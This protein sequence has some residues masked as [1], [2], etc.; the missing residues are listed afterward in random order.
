LSTRREL[1][2]AVALCLLGSVLV[3]LAVSRTW[4]S[5]RTAAAAPLPSKSF[6]VIGT[7]LAPGARALALVGLAGTAAILA[8]RGLGR[9]V[10]GV[11]V[12]A[13]GAG[14]MAVVVRALADPDAAMRRAGPFVDV[15]VAPGA[16]LGPWPYVALFGALL[17]GIAGLVVVVRGRS[18]AAMSSR[19]D[20]PADRKVGEGSLW[21][22]LD[23]GEDP[24]NV[25]SEGGG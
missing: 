1:L 21:E 7:H 17:I 8:T 23:R 15:H 10:V 18:W 16:D 19:Y 9:A 14:V 5:Y 20:A 2:T 13:A 4:V 6:E 22:A 11:L 25:G 3:L 12:T 24:T